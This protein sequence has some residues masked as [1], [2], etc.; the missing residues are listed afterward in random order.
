MSFR[1]LS[2]KSDKPKK[3]KKTTQVLPRTAP[4]WFWFFCFF[5]FF[6]F[7]WFVFFSLLFVMQKIFVCWSNVCQRVEFLHLPKVCLDWHAFYVHFAHARAPLFWKKTSALLPSRE[8]RQRANKKPETITGARLRR[9]AIIMRM[10]TASTG[11][12]QLWTFVSG[13]VS[14][15]WSFIC[16]TV[17][18]IW[19]VETHA[20]PFDRK[21]PFH[22]SSTWLLRF[23]MG[24]S[25]LPQ[26]LK[27]NLPYSLFGPGR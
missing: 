24:Y 25:S 19:I 26:Q 3:T 10:F 5:W 17:L 21:C 11:R 4:P 9:M 20:F 12:W 1:F 7:F 6:V 18:W 15:V 27:M 14:R 22:I 16:K 2:A 13:V 8:K 23:K